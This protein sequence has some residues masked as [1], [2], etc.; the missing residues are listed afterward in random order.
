MTIFLPDTSTLIEVFRARADR[1]RQ[2]LAL[3]AQGH[4]LACCAITVGEIYSGVRPQEIAA[5]EEFVTGLLW[6][7]SSFAIAKRAGLLRNEW[8]RKGKILTLTDTMIA[9]TVLQYGL[10]LILPITGRT[11]R[12]RS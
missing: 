5:T 6:L 2:L 12:C 10:T 11:S 3:G 7:D 9:A 4:S 8:A 1:K